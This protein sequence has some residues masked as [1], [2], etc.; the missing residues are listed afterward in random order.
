M[1]AVEW[2][3]FLIILPTSSSACTPVACSPCEATFHVATMRVL[4]RVSVLVEVK[5][6]P[7]AAMQLPVK[8]RFCAKFN[9]VQGEVNRTESQLD[10]GRWLCLESTA[11]LDQSVPEVVRQPRND[12]PARR[13]ACRSSPACACNRQA[14][15]VLQHISTRWS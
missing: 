2:S 10:D 9:K 14:F 1:S 7:S 8:F 15:K 5:A 12:L 11:I 4:V 6:A 13:T 3:V